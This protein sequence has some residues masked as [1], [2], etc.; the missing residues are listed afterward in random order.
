MC[1][2]FIQNIIILCVGLGLIPSYVL[3]IYM[4]I[5]QN[6]QKNK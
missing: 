3:G 6:N 4:Q 1:M 2:V 5:F